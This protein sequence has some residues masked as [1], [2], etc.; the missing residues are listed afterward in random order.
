MLPGALV[1]AEWLADHADDVR[2]VDV[3]SYLDGRSGYDAYRSGHIPGAMW[4][5]LDNELSNP[6]APLGEV[7]GRHPLPSPERF[8]A[9]MRR[10]GVDDDTPVV[11]YD[12]THGARAARLWWMLDVLDHPAA[13]LDGGLPAWRGEKST[14]AVDHGP[15]DF[16]ER[17]W[18]AQRIVDAAAVADAAA[19]DDAVVIDAR[20]TTRFRGEENPIDH[21]FGH[22]PGARSMPWAGN[23]GD[24]GLFL[25][26]DALADRYGAVGIDGSRDVI[27]Y[28]GSG[29]TACH[30]LLAMRQLGLH[31]RLYV[32]SWSEWGGDLDKPVETG[33]GDLT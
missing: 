3:R 22:I 8:A 15:G 11:A 18:P 27:A 1:S 19:R 30:D 9:A 25:D 14:A 16:T 20:A 24:D 32:G 12:D 28:C 26:A 6:A 29:V 23:V 4:V 13:V 10:V 33:D 7:G 21:R 31:G 5:D 2:V 17:P